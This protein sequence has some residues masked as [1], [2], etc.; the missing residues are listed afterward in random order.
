MNFVEHIALENGHSCRYPIQEINDSDSI[1][2]VLSVWLDNAI[3]TGSIVPLPLDGLSHFGANVIHK[4]GLVVTVSGP[5][6]SY[7]PG[8]IYTGEYVPLFTFGVARKSRESAK[9]WLQLTSE[10]QS[11]KGLKM[12]FTPWCAVAA[13]PSCKTFEGGLHWFADFERRIACVWIMRNRN[14]V[15]SLHKK[16]SL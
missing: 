5:S 16:A 3:N 12:P 6:D 13:H 2:S 9:L 15:L 1:S 14:D 10:F 11:K 7:V 4:V 8:Q